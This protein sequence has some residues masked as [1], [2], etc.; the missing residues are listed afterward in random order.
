VSTLIDERLNAALSPVDTAAAERLRDITELR[1]LVLA[2]NATVT[3]QA[4]TTAAAAADAAS[5]LSSVTAA[6]DAAAAAAQDAVRV[7]LAEWA[8]SP[9]A[10]R[11]GGEGGSTCA[12]CDGVQA[13]VDAAMAK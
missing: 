9:A 13:L 2:L 6:S 12:P 11:G 7:A 8:A 10:Q 5:A 1:A 3:A 4:A